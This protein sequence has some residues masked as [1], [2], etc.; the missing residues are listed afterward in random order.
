MFSSSEEVNEAALSSIELMS[1]AKSSVPETVPA[2]PTSA[3]SLSI[4][5][6]V[7][8]DGSLLDDE[9]SKSS[10]KKKKKKKKKER[11]SMRAPFY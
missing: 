5:F 4:S 11:K 3:S 7:A 9:L 2:A 1:A 8:P 6:A 10:Y